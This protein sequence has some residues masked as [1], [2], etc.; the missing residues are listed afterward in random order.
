MTRV[1]YLDCVG[2]LAGDMLLAA[3]LDAGAQAEVL[4][5]VPVTQRDCVVVLGDGRLGNLCAQVLAGATAGAG[6]FVCSTLLI[7]YSKKL[8][9]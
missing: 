9:V 3:L 1:A 8:P 4:E 7:D 6:L 5:Q 2:G